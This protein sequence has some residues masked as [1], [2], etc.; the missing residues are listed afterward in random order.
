M[1]KTVDC[2]STTINKAIA[3]LQRIDNFNESSKYTR[4]KKTDRVEIDALFGLMYFRGILG[5]NLHMTDKLFSHDSHFVFGAIMSKNRFRF[6]KGHICFDNPQER[7]QLWETDRFAAVREIW[8]IFN[9]NL[10]KHVAP[11][12]YLLI[13]ETLYPMRQQITFRQYNPNKPHLY[14]LL[15]KS[16]N[17][18]RFPHTCKAVQYPAKP[19]TGD[20]LYYLKSTIEYIKYLVTE[21]EANQP[22]T[23]RIIS[24]DHLYTSIESTNWLLDRGIATIGTLK[25]GRSGR[26]FEIFD[27]PNREIFNATCH[28]EKEKKNI[29]LTS[30]TVK[31]K[32][33]GKKNVVVLSTSR[34]L[35]DKAINDG[36]K[37]LQ[38]I[39]FYELKKGGTDIVDQ[40]ND[41][42]TTRSKS[43]RRLMVALSY[44]VDTARVN[45]K[46]VWCLKNDSDISSTS[47]CDFSWNLV[48]AL[49]LA[50]VQRTGLMAWHP[51]CS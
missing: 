16:L 10:S 35:Y 3:R 41:Y 9:S 48:K 43:D 19:K 26:P 7:T 40:L 46:T 12:E 31:T 24:A 38:I 1:D 36:K 20:G 37:K 8:E 29:Y 13:D 44:M 23:G 25:K 28:F 47:S 17:D 30:Y 42:H 18:A 45:R 51:A 14:G 39:K 27:I 21:M 11:L 22:I 34:P 32:S 50:H 5:V 2:T 15:R 49:A 33:K 6:L 4:V